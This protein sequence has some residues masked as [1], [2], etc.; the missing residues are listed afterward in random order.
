MPANTKDDKRQIA[1][2][3]YRVLCSYPLC[4]ANN[5]T[6]SM[7]RVP[8]DYNGKAYCCEEHLTAMTIYIPEGCKIED[9]CFEDECSRCLGGP[10]PC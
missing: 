2:L 8:P 4:A 5:G 10:P 7:V 3:E 1:G 6:P 9:P